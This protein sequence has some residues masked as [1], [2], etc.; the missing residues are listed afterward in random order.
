MISRVLMALDRKVQA[1]TI[2]E[3]LTAMIL[4]TIIFMLAMTI[5]GNLVRTMF[6]AKKMKAE[7]IVQKRLTTEFERA[8]ALSEYSELVDDFTIEQ[9]L[10]TFDGEQPLTE[11]SLTAFDSNGKELICLKGLI[12]K[13]S[14]GK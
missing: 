13:R 7:A 10:K 12:Y 9:K 5:Y 3:V 4:I 6:T 2:P 11:V 8:D 14:D 1:S